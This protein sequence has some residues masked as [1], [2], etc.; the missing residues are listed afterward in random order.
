MADFQSKQSIFNGQL[1]TKQPWQI[2]NTYIS[3][4]LHSN[5]ALLKNLP[6]MIWYSYKFYRFFST[7]INR[8]KDTFK[9]A[10]Y[11]KTIRFHFT[12]QY[13]YFDGVE[14][15]GGWLGSS[16]GVNRL[17]KTFKNKWINK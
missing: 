9:N 17:I 12:L 7:V 14:N 4:P 16:K 1:L 15:V 8:I 3:K 13:Q 11:S 10:T 2:T 5:K 6:N